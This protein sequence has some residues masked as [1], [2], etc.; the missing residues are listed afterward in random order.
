[1]HEVEVIEDPAS[2]AIA[3]HPLR[4][5]MLAELRR[6]A[7]A[8]AL[9]ERLG[10]PRQKVNYHLRTLEAHGLLSMAEERKHG[11]L[12]ERLLVASAASYM[13]SPAAMGDSMP[14]PATLRDR[15]S[16]RYL[17]ALA[18]RLVREVAALVRRADAAGKRLPTLAIDTELRFA[19]AGDQARFADELTA[20]VTRL[21]AKYH[22]DDGRP[23][24]L[25]LAAHPTP[26][27]EEA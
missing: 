27:R 16:A 12:T 13:V 23:Y 24:R 8:A 25:V 26:R 11:G 4:L 5:R 18:A 19:N 7:S 21:A 20:A 22:D 17:I 3:L 6:P 10:L 15:L 14:D 1:M 2:A 9:A